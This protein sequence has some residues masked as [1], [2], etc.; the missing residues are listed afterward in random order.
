M[1]GKFPKI[2]GSRPPLRYLPPTVSRKVGTSGQM[3]KF[4]QGI[5]K[6]SSTHFAKNAF[7]K[8]LC[9]PVYNVKHVINASPKCSPA[10]FYC[11]NHARGFCEY[12]ILFYSKTFPSHTFLD[13]GSPCHR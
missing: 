8:V 13:A 7:R 6:L 2:Q 3:G 5:V 10:T 12:F 9:A 4:S 1:D 11:G